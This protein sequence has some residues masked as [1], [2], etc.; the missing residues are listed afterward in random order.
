MEQPTTLSTE[1]DEDQGVYGPPRTQAILDLL[2][3]WEHDDPEEQRETWEYL[4]VALDED[5]RGARSVY[6]YP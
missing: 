6:P 5:R 3:S 2:E 1:P 4:K